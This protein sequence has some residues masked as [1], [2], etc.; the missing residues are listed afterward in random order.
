M[1]SEGLSYSNNSLIWLISKDLQFN[2]YKY[3]IDS[4][5][6]F[7]KQ[8]VSEKLITEKNLKILLDIIS[9]TLPVSKIIQNNDSDPSKHDRMYKKDKLTEDEMLHAKKI[10]NYQCTK[11]TKSAAYSWLLSFEPYCYS[12]SQLK[13][14]FNV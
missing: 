11:M 4:N 8:F 7:L 9:N 3:S 13:N 12:E 6:P 2:S 10:F 14:E 5:N 1:I